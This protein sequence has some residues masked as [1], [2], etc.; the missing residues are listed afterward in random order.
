VNSLGL[1]TCFFV[2]LGD[3]HGMMALG[4]AG[5]FIGIY[6]VNRRALRS[7]IDFTESET[8]HGKEN[9]NSLTP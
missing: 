5:I 9:A 7:P 8:M 4:A 1:G 6:L 3:I 2:L